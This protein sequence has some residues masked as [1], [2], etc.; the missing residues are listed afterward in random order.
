MDFLVTPGGAY[1]SEI[2]PNFR[3]ARRTASYE[4][5]RRLGPTPVREPFEPVD[6]PGAVLDCASSPG[7]QHLAQFRWAGVLPTPIVS[8]DWQGSIG[9]PGHTASMQLT[10]PRGRWDVSLQY[11]SF[12]G[13]V[14]CGPRLHKVIA[15]NYGLMGEYW[16]AGTLT[17]SGR[18]FT[19]S[20]TSEKRTRFGRL[21]GS[22]RSS[23]SADTPGL[24]PLWRAAFTRH[25][26]TPQRVPVTE[27]CGR[28][29]DWFAPAGS[30]MH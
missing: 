20:L 18:P 4:L 10:L 1:R 27:A 8:T 9:V 21:L 22:P 15:P 26:A 17:S 24:T 6:Q 29:V 25:G 28:Y 13:L 11:V 19:L 12:T 14:V 30:S 2:P 23:L 3:L 16:P 5:Y 7:K